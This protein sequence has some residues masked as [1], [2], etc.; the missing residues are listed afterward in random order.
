M[1]FYLLPRSPLYIYKHL[2]YDACDENEIP[3]NIISQSLCYYLYNIKEKITSREKQWDIF[4][5]YTN[6]YEYIHS[7]VPNKNKSVSNY[8]PISRSYFK[9]IEIIHL[10]TIHF[11]E[12]IR[13]FHL[14]EGPGGFIEAIVNMRNCKDDIYIG[15][16][17]LDE[18]KNDTNIPAWKKSNTFLKANPNVVLEN[19]IDQTGNILCFRTSFMLLINILL[20][21]I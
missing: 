5:K 7:I 3:T 4:K 17:L 14:A 15:M 13:T 8:K 10:F 19:G 6:P 16:T 21:W 9:M 12:P 11:R 18:N 1:S 20:K 2:H